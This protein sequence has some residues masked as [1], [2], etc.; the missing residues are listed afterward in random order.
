MKT[1]IGYRIDGHC[2]VEVHCEPLT[3]VPPTR[4][5]LACVPVETELEPGM[6][7][8]P[9]RRSRFVKNAEIGF[10]WGN[11]SFRASQFAISLL[12]DVLGDQPIGMA[13]AADFAVEVVQRLEDSFDL[14]DRD[15][16][17]WYAGWQARAQE[18]SSEELVGV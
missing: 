7:F 16:L 4:R 9:I 2:A 18:T 17:D 10:D 5:R 8:L 15:I 6:Y 1:Y 3:R 14:T 13:L 11:N 12:A